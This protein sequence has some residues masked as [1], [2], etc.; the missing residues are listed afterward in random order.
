ML[1][2]V[3]FGPFFLTICG[4]SFAALLKKNRTKECFL[5]F[6]ASRN[7]ILQNGENCANTSVF[8]RRWP[9]KKVNTVIFATRGKKM[10]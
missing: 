8:A 3:D 5:S 4:Q 2:E 1:L 6:F 9:T 10:S 7:Y